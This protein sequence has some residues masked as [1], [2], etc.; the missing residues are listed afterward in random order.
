MCSGNLAWRMRAG[1]QLDASRLP[2]LKIANFSFTNVCWKL[3]VAHAYWDTARCLTLADLLPRLKSLSTA[4]FHT[5][6]SLECSMDWCHSHE[7][8]P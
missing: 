2:I 7:M 8:V 5:F 4:Q 3:G 6:D 1:I